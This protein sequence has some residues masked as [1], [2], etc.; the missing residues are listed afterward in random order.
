MDFE[1]DSNLLT[2]TERILVENYFPFFP[3][4]CTYTF[5]LLVFQREEGK[6]HTFDYVHRN[7]VYLEH[8]TT[9]TYHMG[10]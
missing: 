5:T 4:F 1:R 10:L 9:L 7:H 3:F 8:S 2:N 6:E